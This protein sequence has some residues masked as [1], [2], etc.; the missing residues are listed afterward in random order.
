MMYPV[1]HDKVNAYVQK[2]SEQKSD[3]EGICLAVHLNLSGS[4]SS[5]PSIDSHLVILELFYKHSL[6]IKAFMAPNINLQKRNFVA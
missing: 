4:T 3:I 2:G 5:R 1:D 6:S